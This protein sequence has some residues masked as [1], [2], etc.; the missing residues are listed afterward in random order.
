[1]KKETTCPVCKND[2]IVYG[3]YFNPKAVHKHQV[4]TP[5]FKPDGLKRFT[6]SD[7]S[8]SLGSEIFCSCLDCGL[9]WSRIDSKKLIRSIQKNGTEATRQ[10]VAFSKKPDETIRPVCPACNDQRLFLGTTTTTTP[11]FRPKGLRFFCIMRKDL[12]PKQENRFVACLNCGLVWSGIDQTKL[13]AL[14][15]EK[16]T[17]LTKQKYQLLTDQ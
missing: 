17:K 9:L 12:V 4:R 7:P 6:L 3:R 8:I 5:R 10:N 11:A 16:G 15:A 13:G 2:R 14:L 1:M